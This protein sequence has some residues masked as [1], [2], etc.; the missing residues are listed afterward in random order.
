M[1][2]NIKYPMSV[3]WAHEIEWSQIE[4]EHLVFKSS[5]APNPTTQAKKLRSHC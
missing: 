5:T 3:S 4:K 1:G 2:I